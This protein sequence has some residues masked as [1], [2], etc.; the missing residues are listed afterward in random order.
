MHHGV[1]EGD[2]IVPHLQ[3]SKLILAPQLIGV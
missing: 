3:L 2:R 1:E